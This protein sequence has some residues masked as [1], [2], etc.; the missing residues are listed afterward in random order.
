MRR[1]IFYIPAILFAIIYGCL[2]IFFSIRSISP[3]IFIWIILFL[4]SGF[5]LN[6]NKVLGGILGM[7]PGIYFIYMS[8][9]YTGQL[10]SE[11]PIGILVLVF[12]MLCSIH[13]YN[14]GNKI[15]TLF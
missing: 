8:T 2:A 10:I 7:V 1:I 6:E 15:R 12:Y 14:K 5:L 11:R 4:V 3:I 13:V 9:K